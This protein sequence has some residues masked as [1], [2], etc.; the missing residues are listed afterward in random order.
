[1]TSLQYHALIAIRHLEHFHYVGN[2]ANAVEVLLF[3]FLRIGRLQEDSYVAA[4][5]SC[6]FK[7]SQRFGATH[8]QRHGHAR[9]EDK[10]L[11]RNDWQ[12]LG[13]K[14]VMIKCEVDHSIAE[15]WNHHCPRCAMII[16]NGI[17]QII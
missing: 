2:A 10:V 6:V 12:M 17:Y 14:F 5:V 16:Y 1:M 11:G 15:Y 3:R 7:S 13:V 8:G 4:L 9:E